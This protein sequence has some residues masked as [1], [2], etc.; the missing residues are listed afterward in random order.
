M[1]VTALAP[2]HLIGLAGGVFNFTGAL[3]A[4]VV[5]IAIGALIDG[6]NF[7]PAL[8][9]IAVLAAIG[10]CSYLFVVGK[11]EHVSAH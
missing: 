6:D 7:A 9:F 1:F 5:P 11:I 10:I 4:I 8:G 2:R 3:S